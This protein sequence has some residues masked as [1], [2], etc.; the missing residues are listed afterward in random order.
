[1]DSQSTK[2]EKN[3]PARL[4][5]RWMTCAAMFLCATAGAQISVNVPAKV[6]WTDTGIFVEQGDRILVVNATGGWSNAGS[7]PSSMKGALGFD[8]YMHPG[9]KLAD[10]SLGALIGRVETSAFQ[11]RPDQVIVAPSRGRLYLGMND[12][13][14]APNYDDN[15]G[16]LDVVLRATPMRL[17]DLQGRTVQEAQA[18]LQHYHQVPIPTDQ[19]S[20][21]PPGQIFEQQ[22]PAGTLIQ[23]VKRVDVQ[24]SDGQPEP[25]VTPNIGVTSTLAPADSFKGGQQIR[26]RIVVRNPGADAARSVDVQIESMNLTDIEI[27]GACSAAPCRIDLL[28]PNSRAGIL[29]QARVAQGAA[30]FFNKVTVT[31]Q[32]G[33]SDPSDNEQTILQPVE[34]EIGAT[35]QS[36]DISLTAVR[37]AVEALS[38]GARTNYQVTVHNEGPDAATNVVVAA[39]GTNV[40]LKFSDGDCSSLACTLTELAAGADATFHVAAELGSPGK[41]SAGFKAAGA[42]QDLDP[43]NNAATIEG[44][45]PNGTGTRRADL[46][47]T[48][49]DVQNDDVYPAESAAFYFVVENKGPAD[50]THVKFDHSAMGIWADGIASECDPS[51]CVIPAGSSLTVQVNATHE[52]PG[53]F[54]VQLQVTAAEQ[55]PDP[56]NNTASYVGR[57]KTPIP[58]IWIACGAIVLLAAGAAGG[59]AIRKRHWRKLVEVHPTFDPD[60]ISSPVISEMPGPPVEV[61]SWVE[62]G[63]AA[64]TTPIRV[65]HEE[66]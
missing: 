43:T 53:K 63:E 45:I 51:N 52:S 40:A 16:S 35:P 58:W 34:P 4:S 36:A 50:A 42:E 14:G 48:L 20:T 26:I 66:D 2:N 65:T 29:V 12:V 31:P 38:P 46:A 32:Q 10:V 21:F 18:L 11:A 47:V 19:H 30:M 28:P 60:D 55:D 44:E 37:D 5:A 64:P 56:E 57:T 1:M 62:F 24:V 33:D 22:P 15:G 39:S 9:T 59:Q 49:R 8:G 54:S 6:E 27:T 41:F 61:N 7:E 3:A 23:A 25:P 17:P 13:P